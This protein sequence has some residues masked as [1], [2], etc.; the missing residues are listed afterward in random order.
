MNEEEVF[1]LARKDLEKL[2]ER[3]L[4]EGI[5]ARPDLEQVLLLDQHFIV[6]SR[7][8]S[9]SAYKQV[10]PYQVF[11]CQGSMFVY[12][13][14]S[15][16][17]EQRLGG[18]YSIGIGG[19]INLEDANSAK[20]CLAEY[21]RALIRERHEELICPEDIE[22]QFI[23][24]INDDSDPVGQVHLGAVHLCKIDSHEDIYI[25]PEGEDLHFA[26]WLN[27][28]E[29]LKRKHYFEKWSVLAARLCQSGTTM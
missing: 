13:R 2:I 12:Q 22:S 24:W 1:C 15:S 19:H 10:I 7:A 17:G 16:V 6:R 23:G 9:D 5:F 4:P 8:E 11:S 25:K 27:H 29:I 26:G 14:G 21:Q 18:L 20:I 3:P 28:S